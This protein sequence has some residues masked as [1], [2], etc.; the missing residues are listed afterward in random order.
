[1]QHVTLIARSAGDGG[2]ANYYDAIKPYLPAAV[3]YCVIHN[4]NAVGLFKKVCSLPPIIWSFTAAM[5]KADLVCLNPSLVPKSYYRD[6]LLLC[7]CRLF[8]EKVIVFFR[9]WDVGFE[10]KITNSRI[11]WFI[12]RK[13]YGTADAFIVLGDVFERKLMHMGVHAPIFK[14]TT[15]ANGHGCSNAAIKERTALIEREIRCLFMARLV[16]GKGIDEAVEMYL[17]LKKRMLN[18][19]VSLTVAGD[20]PE[21]HRLKTLLRKKHITDVKLVGYVKASAKEELLSRM[22]L[23]LLPTTYG[24]GMP[25]SVLEAMLYG[26]IIVST[27]VGGIPDV[28]SDGINGFLFEINERHNVVERL[29]GLLRDRGKVAH[30]AILNQ[31]TACESFVPEKVA[32]RLMHILDSVLTESAIWTEKG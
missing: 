9:G 30:M 29:S 13:T 2:V 19:Q 22:H 5:R 23:L 18:H 24:E 12:F 26:L 20:G 6:M 3:E 1:M 17:A 14:M 4:P 15:V 8:R 27:P 21:L 7:L 25:N 31:Q 11:G 28:V 10:D 16:P 32:Q